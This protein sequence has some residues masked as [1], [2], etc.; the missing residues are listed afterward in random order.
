MRAGAARLPDQAAQRR[1]AARSCST[2]ELEQR[3]AARARRASCARAL[4]ER[5]QLRATS[6]AARPPMQA[7]FK[8]VAQVAPSRASVLITG[9]S[10]HRQ[11][12]D[13]GRDPR[14]QPARQ[15][16]VRDAALRGAGRDAA[17]ERAVRPRARRVHRRGRRAAT[18]ASSRPTA[19]RCSST[20]SAR[21]RRR[22]RSSCCA[23]CRSASSSAS[24]ATRRSRVDVRVIAATNRDLAA[25]GRG[26]ASSART[27]TT[28]STSSPSRCRRCASARRTSRCWPSTSCASTP[29]EN[30][31][32]IDGFSRRGARA[33]SRR[34][35]WPGNVRE[36]EN[37][38]ERAVVL[39]QTAADRRR[40]AA[41]AASRRGQGARRPRRSPARRMDEIERYAI[42]K[43]L[44]AT[45]GSTSQGRRDPRHQRAQDPVQAARVRGR[46]QVVARAGRRGARNDTRSRSTCPRG[47]TRSA[48][49]SRSPPPSS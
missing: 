22:C 34:Y 36:L 23:S 13:R 49:N 41:A 15:G 48:A 39:A 6:S 12:A 16:P 26:R 30:G 44:E 14:A 32:T 19:A 47:R 4:A 37:V 43:T 11:G 18:G 5:V 8:T 45:G 46:A 2:R 10:G 28:G 7:V 29:T 35:D 25:D 3:A 21:S 42:L 27:S 40:R 33:R 38:V 17:R 20:R 9:E 1:R 31:K 24:A